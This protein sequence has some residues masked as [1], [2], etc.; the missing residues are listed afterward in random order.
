[1]VIGDII[2]TLFVSFS[3]FIYLNQGSVNM[4][5]NPPKGDGHRNGMV[6]GRSQVKNPLTGN[7]VKRDTETGQFIDQKADG[8][9]FKGVRKEK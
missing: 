9:P 2:P 4:A 3:G 8:E 5:T 6:K 1:M 7:Y